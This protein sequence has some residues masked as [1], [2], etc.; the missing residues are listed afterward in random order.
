MQTPTAAITNATLTVGQSSGS[1]TLI[2]PSGYVTTLTLS[3][4]ADGSSG[5]VKVSVSTALPAGVS[6]PVATARV[7]EAIGA[8]VA[9]LVYV[10]VLP[11]SRLSFRATPAFSF[12]LRGGTALTAGSSAYVAYYDPA[13]SATGWVPI[14]GPGSVNG[15]TISFPATAGTVNL[16]AGSLYTFAL[17]TSSQAISINPLGAP[18]SVDPAAVAFAGLGSSFTQ[19]VAV[20]ESSGTS[21]PAI[22]NYAFTTSSG[23]CPSTSFSYTPAAG[24][25]ALATTISIFQTVMVSAPSC[26]LT[27]TDQFNN[28]TS[29]TL[30]PASPP[31]LAV[32]PATVTLAGVGT[33]YAAPVAATESNGSVVVLQSIAFAPACPGF[34]Y[35]NGA[36]AA[37]LAIQVF[38]VQP[39]VGACTLVLTDS[40]NNTA[41]VTVTLPNANNISVG[42]S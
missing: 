33:S 35:T 3:A 9:P 21:A 41:R 23:A 28:V 14:L 2:D 27:L 29:V 1:A 16:A 22:T 8:N 15:Q 39:S 6:T 36:S 38:A 24:P 13:K 7:P 37:S 40:W 18:L 25:G 19:K 20:T 32:S 11:S 5:T 17:F 10:T 34:S 42:G 26:V 12:T 31:T 4:T 30:T